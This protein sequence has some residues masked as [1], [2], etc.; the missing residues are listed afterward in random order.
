MQ[1]GCTTCY[2]TKNG[3]AIQVSPGYPREL[4]LCKSMFEPVSTLDHPGTEPG[5]ILVHTWVDR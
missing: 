3:D 1:G 2:Y 5:N 4:I